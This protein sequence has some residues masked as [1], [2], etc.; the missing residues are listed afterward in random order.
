MTIVKNAMLPASLSEILA[1]IGKLNTASDDFKNSIISLKESLD[2]LG[3][4]S[5]T[6]SEIKNYVNTLSGLADR[7]SE[8]TN[9]VSM[10]QV[11]SE[12]QTSS[13]EN[14]SEQLADLD[15]RVDTLETAA[16]EFFGG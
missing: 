4:I 7:V 16:D 12:Q 6:V 10:L 15:G 13:N 14:V 2:A 9:A 1:E 3:D 5:G 11:E 8:L